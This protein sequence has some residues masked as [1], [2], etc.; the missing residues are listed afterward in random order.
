MER[1]YVWVIIICGIVTMVNA[2]VTA[3]M[4]RWMLYTRHYEIK[5][6]STIAL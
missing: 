3:P 5:W 4:L 6:N 2:Y 1:N